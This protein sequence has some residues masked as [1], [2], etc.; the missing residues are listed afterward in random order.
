MRSTPGSRSHSRPT[1][2]PTSRPGSPPPIHRASSVNVVRRPGTQDNSNAAEHPVRGEYGGT[3]FVSMASRTFNQNR[4]DL[5]PQPLGDMSFPLESDDVLRNECGNVDHAFHHGLNFSNPTVRRDYLNAEKHKQRTP[6]NDTDYAHRSAAVGSTAG[7]PISRDTLSPS[8]RA[9]TTADWDRS[10]IAPPRRPFARSMSASLPATPPN[11][12]AEKDTMPRFR[13]RLGTPGEYPYGPDMRLGSSTAASVPHK[14]YSEVP[15]RLI[16]RNSSILALRKSRAALLEA[17]RHAAG[18]PRPMPTGRATSDCTSEQHVRGTF[19]N[20]RPPIY[21][22]PC[23]AYKQSPDPPRVV[24]SNDR[25]VLEAASDDESDPL[26][27]ISPLSSRSFPT[28]AHDNNTL[29]SV[30]QTS[31]RSDHTK[32]EVDATKVTVAQ[33]WQ[34]RKAGHHLKSQRSPF[35]FNV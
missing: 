17:A 30:A 8:V 28:K 26:P 6:Y 2:R 14:D 20:M 24:F 9:V 32:E 16:S 29:R 11:E 19:S 22:G 1:S 10:N 31:D 27:H 23:V 15:E 33:L 7:R 21:D 13:A 5:H 25:V 34:E 12:P 3:E 4:Y 18:E 35:S